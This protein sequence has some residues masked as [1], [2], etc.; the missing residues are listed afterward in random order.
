MF[1]LSSLVG[2]SQKNIFEVA[3]SGSVND[4][5][6]LMAIN[7]DT[8]NTVENSGYLPLILACYNGNREV[9]VF[10]IERVKDIN[11]TSKM[12]TPLMAAVFKDD[13]AIVEAL[14]AMN[15]D[16]NIADA[17]GT[18]ALHYAI[19]NRNEAVIKLLLDANAD[20]S[21]KDKRGNSALDYG[22]MTQN[23]I[24]INLL[25]RNKI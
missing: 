15:A 19:L 7:A 10:L 3:R 1:F 11:G 4:V 13:V 21:F 25:K 2:H 9:A 24:I 16:P 20:V 5:K 8:I 22:K 17:N 14:L 23:Q 18:S 6:A 12:G